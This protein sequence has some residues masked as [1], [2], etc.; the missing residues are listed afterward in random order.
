MLTSVPVVGNGP[1]RLQIQEL[2]GYYLVNLEIR[3][4]TERFGRE[5]PCS[6]PDVSNENFPCLVQIGDK[7]L[8]SFIKFGENVFTVNPLSDKKLSGMAM[9]TGS[10][11]IPYTRRNSS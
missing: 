7:Y 6:L 11:L 2:P 9:I 5:I 8:K 4:D 1:S 10:G 3:L